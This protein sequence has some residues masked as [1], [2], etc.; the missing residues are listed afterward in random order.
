MI[1]TLSAF[2]RQSGLLVV[3]SVCIRNTDSFILCVHARLIASAFDHT[4]TH[5]RT[6]AR[7]HARAHARTHHYSIATKVFAMHCA[8]LPLML[9]YF[10]D[11]C[12]M[13]S[14]L[15]SV[16]RYSVQNAQNKGLR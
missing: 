7:T 14:R 6:H 3:V 8:R 1:Y 11:G 12:K 13:T 2:W 4:H 15:F 5:T 9:T 16:G 10:I